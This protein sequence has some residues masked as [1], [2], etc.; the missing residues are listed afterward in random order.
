MRGQ[1]SLTKQIAQAWNLDQLLRSPDET[2]QSIWK[3]AVA[4]VRQRRIRE[5]EDASNK[6]PPLEQ[7]FKE[8]LKD[9]DWDL[10]AEQVV[11]A[12]DNDLATKI[13]E[14]LTARQANATARPNATI[15][16]RWRLPPPAPSSCQPNTNRQDSPLRARVSPS[17]PRTAEPTVNHQPHAIDGTPS[18]ENVIVEYLAK[19]KQTEISYRNYF[20]MV[21][22]ARDLVLLPMDFIDE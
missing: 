7:A 1:K 21:R 2:S 13:K 12:Y 16:G 15:P 22:R 11:T 19:Q 6:I 8:T 14:G 18:L 10:N 3:K 9:I 4:V 20:A 17:P 5:W